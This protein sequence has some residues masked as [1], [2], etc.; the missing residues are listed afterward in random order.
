[1]TLG[2][3]SMVC[4]AERLDFDTIDG[5]NIFF[6]Y[7]CYGS[8]ETVFTKSRV[9]SR[10]NDFEHNYLDTQTHSLYTSD[11]TKTFFCVPKF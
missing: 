8:L 1:M 5:N 10:C 9:N 6:A 11:L 3:G 4:S 2:Y 7:L